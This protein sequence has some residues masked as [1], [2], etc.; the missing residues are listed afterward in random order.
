MLRVGLLSSDDGDRYSV[1][2]VCGEEKSIGI[3]GEV[4]SSWY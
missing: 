3:I 1:D 4:F 2:G